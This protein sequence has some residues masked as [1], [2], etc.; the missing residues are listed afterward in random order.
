MLGVWTQ[1]KGHERTQENPGHLQAR[2]EVLRGIITNGILILDFQLAEYKEYVSSV[3][4]PARVGFHDG[5]PGMLI[6]DGYGT[7]Y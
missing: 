3:L 1:S 6:E 7:N 5:N 4:T 2:R